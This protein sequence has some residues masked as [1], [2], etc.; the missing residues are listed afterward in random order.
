MHAYI[1]EY[2]TTRDV[3]PDEEMMCDIS[4][5]SHD[6]IHKIVTEYFKEK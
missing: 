3:E 6:I 1:R 4:A 2:L 5:N